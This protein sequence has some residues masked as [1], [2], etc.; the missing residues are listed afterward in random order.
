MGVVHSDI[1]SPEVI[2]II[3][4]ICGLLQGGDVLVRLVASLL[5]KHCNLGDILVY[6]FF[7]FPDLRGRPAFRF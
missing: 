3:G 5:K 6:G 2:A 1:M 7:V 4:L